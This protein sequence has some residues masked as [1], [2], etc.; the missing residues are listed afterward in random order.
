MVRVRNGSSSQRRQ[1]GGR[2]SQLLGV[3]IN[4]DSVECFLQDDMMA[5]TSDNNST[6]TADGGGDPS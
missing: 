1:G 3:A 6:G 4:K 5:N 2:R